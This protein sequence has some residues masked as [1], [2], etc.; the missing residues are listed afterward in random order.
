MQA[1]NGHST[2]G[3]G[4]RVAHTD[5][6][7]ETFTPETIYEQ[8]TH[9]DKGEVADV[10]LRM[11]SDLVE[12]GRK[13]AELSRDVEPNQNDLRALEEHAEAMANE[14]YRDPYDPENNQEHKLRETEYQKLKGI[15]PEA[16]LAVSYAEADHAKL[17]DE[18]SQAQSNMKPP[19]T[20]QVLMISAVS[21]LALTIAPTLH[22]YVFITMKDD[23]LNWAISL[24]SATVYGIF[25][26]WGLLDSDD[27]GG[28]RTVRNR[29]GFAGGIVVPVGLGILRA[30]NAV[31]T[32][33]LLFAVA[34]TVVEIGIVV[35]LEARANSL[36]VAYQEWA[37]QQA[38]L[39]D[40]TTRLEEAR[41][42]LSR[43]NKKLNEINDAID[44]HVRLVTE[45]SLRNYNIEKVKADAM[46]AV[47]DGYFDGLAI[48]RGYLRGVRR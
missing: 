48:N 26:T 13:R 27:A 15:R 24:L 33:E 14:A 43:C 22:D 42:H 45:L 30:A 12:Y 47:R 16:E 7:A 21:G 1:T 38:L 40:V 46:K 17:V 32:A 28:R 31:G 41:S 25:I 8:S 2:R 10:V 11:H 6:R 34:L 37:A 4:F 5:R 44:A 20:Q 29:L 36:R 39:K 18:A 23:V 35:L 19:T 9:T 3:N